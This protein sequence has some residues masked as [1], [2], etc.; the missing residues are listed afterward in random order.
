MIGAL[1]GDIIGSVYEFNNIKTKD[2]PLFSKES[3][4]TDDSIMTIAVADWLLHWR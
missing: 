1:A 3:F 4:Y 2:F